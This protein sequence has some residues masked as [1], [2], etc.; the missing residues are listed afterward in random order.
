MGGVK[1]RGIYRERREWHHS[2]PNSFPSALLYSHIAALYDTCAGV[3]IGLIKQ[4]TSLLCLQWCRCRRHA[5]T[6]CT[7]LLAFGLWYPPPTKK[8]WYSI[9]K[10]CTLILNG[11]PLFSRFAIILVC[12]MMEMGRRIHLL[13][14]VKTKKKPFMYLWSCLFSLFVFELDRHGCLVD[15]SVDWL[16]NREFKT[17]TV[18]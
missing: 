1:I 5:P 8:Y 14:Y 12:M 13:L 2:H 9:L 4:G 17:P 11:A 6:V 18:L 16:I 3:R 10:R 15:P 7:L